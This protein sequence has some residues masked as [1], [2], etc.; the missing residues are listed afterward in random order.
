MAKLKNRIIHLFTSNY[1]R[2]MIAGIFILLGG[3]LGTDGLLEIESQQDFWN[4]V[5]YIGV[6]ILLLYVVFG[7]FYAIKNA[8]GDIKGK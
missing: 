5:M 7:I 3:V 2:L 4:V 6:A 1:G 8:V